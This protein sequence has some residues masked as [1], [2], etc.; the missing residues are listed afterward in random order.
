MD[1]G[2]TTPGSPTEVADPKHEGYSMFDERA[3]FGGAAHIQRKLGAYY[4]SSATAMHMARWLLRGDVRSVLEPSFGGGVFLDA[5]RVAQQE[6][7]VKRV[8]IIGAEISESEVDRIVSDGLL[9]AANIHHGDFL[10]MKPTPVDAV[11]G[12]P[13]YVRLRNLSECDRGT[14]LRV[15]HAKL[16]APMDTSG[17]LWMPFVLH[18]MSFLK[19]GG[20]LALVLP[21]EFTYV[22]YALDLWQTLASS[23]GSLRIV[24]VHERLFPD[25]LQEVVLLYAADFGSSCST[26]RFSAF[27]RIHSFLAEMPVCD[28]DLPIRNIVAGE[29]SFVHA[30]LPDALVE[31][32]A[33][34]GGADMEMIKERCSFNIGYVCGDKDFFH[35]SP[36]ARQSFGLRRTSLRQA[37]TSSRQLKGGGLRSSNLRPTEMDSLFLPPI[38]VGALSR[39]D[40]QYIKWGEAN[41]VDK[42]YK[43]QVRSPWYQVPGVKVPDLLLSVFADRP[44]MILND[45]EYIATNSLLC[46]YMKKGRADTLAAGWYTSLSL[47][48][49]ELEVHSLG[50]GV[51]ILVPNEVGRVRVPK[52]SRV[53]KAYLT[54]LDAALRTGNETA[55]YELGDS[56]VL[57]ALLG[58][59]AQEVKLIKDGLQ[60]LKHWRTSAQSQKSQRVSATHRKGVIKNVQEEMALLEG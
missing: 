30:L 14:A 36:E 46:G 34:R 41:R 24:R 52:V 53:T 2:Y 50:G 21:Y 57:R 9:A 40:K 51:M 28:R 23:F 20:R 6:L 7:D 31:L 17:S 60:I 12:N 5:I 39:E 37:V 26:V 15:A 59:S 16:R 19:K 4:T 58:F 44:L 25:I 22:K 42:R 8:R 18:S 35:P 54:R 29:R 56:E 10:T 11:I 33:R 49:C 13:P 47:L 48:N 55:A 45:G 27:E 32:I 38:D 43:C 3:T 1:R